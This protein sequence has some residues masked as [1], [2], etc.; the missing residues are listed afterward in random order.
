VPIV[1]PIVGAILGAWLY[2]A[3]VNKHHPSPEVG[4]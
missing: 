1:A 2:D 4:R 3:F